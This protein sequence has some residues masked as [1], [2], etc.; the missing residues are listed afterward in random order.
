MQIRLQTER[1]KSKSPEGAGKLNFDASIGTTF[2]N[3]VKIVI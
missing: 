1:R 2:L 3:R